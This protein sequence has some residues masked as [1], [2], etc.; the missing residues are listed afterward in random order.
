MLVNL[1]TLNVVDGHDKA[2]ENN[3]RDQARGRLG[4]DTP[5]ATFWD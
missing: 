4:S 3:H 1:E 2:R 5:C